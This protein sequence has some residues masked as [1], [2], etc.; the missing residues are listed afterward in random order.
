ML[1][2]I[3]DKENETLVKL[4]T[5]DGRD[6]YICQGNPILNLP[7]VKSIFNQKGKIPIISEYFAYIPQNIFPNFKE[8]KYP[9]I[10]G[11]CEK[12]EKKIYY[13]R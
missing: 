7:I 12:I 5:S 1:G 11:N 9:K 13:F 8:E 3:L 2:N 6:F 4:E 10:I